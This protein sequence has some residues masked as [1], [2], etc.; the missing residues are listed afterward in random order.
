MFYMH[1]RA[2]FLDEEMPDG[3]NVM[4]WFCVLGIYAQAAGVVLLKDLNRMLGTGCRVGGMA[5]TYIGFAGIVIYA[6]TFAPITATAVIC[7]MT[8]LVIEAVCRLGVVAMDELMAGQDMKAMKA[9]VDDMNAANTYVVTLSLLMLYIHFRA[10]MVLELDGPPEWVEF[11]MVLVTLG[12]LVTIGM[13][14]A[15]GTVLGKEV[16]DPTTNETRVVVE[17]AWASWV[18]RGAILAMYFGFVGIMLAALLVMYPEAN[19]Y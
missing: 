8:L 3:A 5:L 19:F 1:F 17:A 13:I 18:K 7:T 9:M 12:I 15:E 6:L 16:T 11:M 14:I 4:I 10:R 2:R